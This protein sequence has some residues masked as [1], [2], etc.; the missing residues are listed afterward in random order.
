MISWATVLGDSGNP[1]WPSLSFGTFGPDESGDHALPESGGGERGSPLRSLR[2]MA[3]LLCPDAIE[4]VVM[5][6]ANRVFVRDL[7]RRRVAA[8]FGYWRA[9]LAQCWEHPGHSRAIR[10]R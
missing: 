6:R 3:R 5:M 2:I 9:I 10:E 4:S 8:Y 1:S 7:R